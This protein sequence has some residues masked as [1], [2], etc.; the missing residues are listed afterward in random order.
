MP[1][2]DYN[3]LLTI[4]P[5][6][7]HDYEDD[8][9]GQGHPYIDLEA[10]HLLGMAWAGL[11]LRGVFTYKFL[12]EGVTLLCDDEDYPRCDIVDTILTTVL[13]GA[14]GGNPDFIDI[15]GLVEFR[16]EVCKAKIWHLNRID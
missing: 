5:Y 9:R 1:Q 12:G 16:G 11:Y 13:D 15:A 4:L 2:V 6:I 8:P 7:R 3:E 10:A 14:S